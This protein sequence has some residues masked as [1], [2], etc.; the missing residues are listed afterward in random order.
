MSRKTV[1]SL[2]YISH[3]LLDPAS[4][5]ADMLALVRTA[6]ERNRTIEV[7]GAL[8]FTGTRFAQI[9]EGPAAAIDALLISIRRDPRHRDIDVIEQVKL[10]ERRFAGWSLAYWGSTTFV[11]GLIDA[12]DR[13]APNASLRADDIGRLTRMI[14]Q[15]ALACDGEPLGRV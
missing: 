15:L 3:S 2:L 8:I 4:A 1:T 12:L 10:P 5:D 11:D 14:R 9:I 13:P 7:T 6:I